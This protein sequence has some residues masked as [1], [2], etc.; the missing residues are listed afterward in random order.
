MIIC[1]F[2]T[3][4]NNT[5]I[6]DKIAKQVWYTLRTLQG[7]FERPLALEAGLQLAEGVH[8][9]QFPQVMQVSTSA[10]CHH[11][12][13]KGCV[14]LVSVRDSQ[15]RSNACLTCGGLGHVQKDCKATLNSQVGDRDDLALSDTNPTISQMSHT[16]T[17]SV[18]ITYLGNW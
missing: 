16:M 13:L 8:L 4:T 2:V 5:S 15:T 14:H 6:V 9:G 17:A 10:S 11:D 7:T 12:V 1:Y 3:S 18:L